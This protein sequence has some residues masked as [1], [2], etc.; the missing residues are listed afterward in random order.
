[1]VNPMN[2]I[3]VMHATAHP[4]TP[5]L[6]AEEMLSALADGELAPAELDC[7]LASG[8]PLAARWSSYHLIGDVLRSPAAATAPTFAADVAA[9]MARVGQEPPLL[10]PATPGPARVRGLAANDAVFR[11]K[12]VAGL[13]SLAAV[14]ALTWQ[15]LV[16]SAAYGG[17][18][19]AEANGPQAAPAPVAVA[20]ATPGAPVAGA[21]QAE[22]AALGPMIRDAELD[23]LL[24]AH[25]QLGGSALQ[26]PAGFLRNATF[27]TPQR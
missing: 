8:E 9:V 26:M 18:T 25:R 5:S 17:A 23:E 7:L 13:A 14:G 10:A 24:A 1:M 12:L 19:L 4:D 16:S 21:A 11:W 3:P 22:S 27:E 20:A 15:T 2:K 6:P